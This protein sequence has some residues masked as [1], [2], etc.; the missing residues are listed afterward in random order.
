MLS[1]VIAVLALAL[2]D[3][4]PESVGYYLIDDPEDKL[5]WGKWNDEQSEL[6]QDSTDG[7]GTKERNLVHMEGKEQFLN[8]CELTSIIQ[9]V[10][11][12][13]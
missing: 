11:K 3:Q 10:P 13:I 1:D 7:S 4:S 9:T 2:L 12:W 6:K 5:V 8:A